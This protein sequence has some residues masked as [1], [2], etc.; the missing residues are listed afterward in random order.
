VI[1]EFDG[2]EC[3]ALG[4][5]VKA[6]MD[7]IATSEHPEIHASEAILLAGISMKCVA[8][9]VVEQAKIKTLMHDMQN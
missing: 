4:K 3:I 6:R 5:I 1:V 2:D 9:I 7:A 8:A